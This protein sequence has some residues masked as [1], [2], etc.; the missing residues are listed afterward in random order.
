MPDPAYTPE[1]L[2]AVLISREVRDGERVGVGT[3]SPV[4]AAGCLL[5]H[6]IHAPG[7]QLFIWRLSEYWPFSEGMKELFDA[8]Q[9]GLL[10]LFFLGGAQIDRQ[11][12]TNL[13][14]IGDYQRPKVRLPG[15]AGS[16]TLSYT[17]PRIIL[18]QANHSKRTFV[19]R[20]DFVTATNDPPPS[21]RRLGRFTRCITPLAVLNFADREPVLEALAPGVTVAQVLE[22][23]GF[24][25]VVAPD[26]REVLPPTP[27]ELGVLRTAVK[28]KMRA[29]YPRF[30]AGALK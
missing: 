27:E 14:A 11:G 13:V 6:Y 29:V 25:L 23:T 15:G 21:V 28:E 1:E 3:L 5:A 10:D 19:E 20:V 8:G 24:P 12:N 9:R 17:V 4:A 7:A 22:N 18:F 16:A 30:C 2:M 26:V